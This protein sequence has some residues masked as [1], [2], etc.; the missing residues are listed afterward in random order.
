MLTEL[1]QSDAALDDLRAA[2]WEEWFDF[3]T[4][5]THWCAEPGAV[6]VTLNGNVYTL[7][8]ERR[9]TLANL[10]GVFA[11][12]G[13]VLAATAGMAAWRKIPLRCTPPPCWRRG[14]R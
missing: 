1:L 9:E 4:A 6:Q 7:P 13:P 14:S 3:V 10:N 11:A 12:Q 8:A 2:T 5:V